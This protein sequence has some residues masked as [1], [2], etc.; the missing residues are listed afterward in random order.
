MSCERDNQHPT[1]TLEG[2]CLVVSVS[3]AASA[4]L[5]IALKKLRVKWKFLLNSI[6]KMWNNVTMDV[7]E[8]LTT[9]DYNLTLLLITINTCAFVWLQSSRDLNVETLKAYDL[10][11]ANKM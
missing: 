9:V 8:G 6:L 5:W 2:G 1:D 3:Y 7:A 10:S 11:I 4:K